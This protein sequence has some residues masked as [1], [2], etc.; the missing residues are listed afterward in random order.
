MDNLLRQLMVQRNP[1]LVLLLEE[2]R[3]SGEAL[4]RTAK[5]LA[6]SGR[7]DVGEVSSIKEAFD[8]LILMDSEFKAKYLNNYDHSKREQVKPYLK[9]I[10][11]KTR[12]LEAD[13]KALGELKE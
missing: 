11:E 10:A 5:D 12:A 2:Y 3:A 9:V 6:D 8:E 7:W 1:E 4:L 13:L